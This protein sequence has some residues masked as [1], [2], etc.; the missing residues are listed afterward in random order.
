MYKCKLLV[1][2]FPLY[3][4]LLCTLQDSIDLFLGNYI[5]EEGEGVAKPSP[6]RQENDWKIVAVSS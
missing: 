1:F 2:F 3:I 4:T 5:V 6:L